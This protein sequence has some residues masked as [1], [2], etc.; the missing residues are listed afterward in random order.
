MSGRRGTAI[1]AALAILLLAGGLLASAAMLASSRAEAGSRARLSLVA[2]AGVRRAVARLLAG[3][4]PTIDSLPVGGAFTRRLALDARD[5][6]AGQPASVLVRVQRLSSATW[7]LAADLQ[8]GAGPTARRRI[9]VV[10]RRAS[11]GDGSP[12]GA[13][14]PIAQWGT[15][16][17]Y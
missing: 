17:L 11:A 9:A 13:L 10:A 14:V 5:R 8:V 4:D 1:V 3:Q 12:S 7:Y 2:E 16:D 15:A 6:S